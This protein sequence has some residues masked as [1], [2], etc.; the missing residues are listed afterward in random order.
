MDAEVLF[1]KEHR[2]SPEI[3]FIPGQKVNMPRAAALDLI[4]RGIVKQLPKLP[5][6]AEGERQKELEELKEQKNKEQDERKKLVE[7]WVLAYYNLGLK[8]IP[9]KGGYHDKRDKEPNIPE[10]STYFYQP[11]PKE[12]IEQWLKEGKYQNVALLGGD[13]A[14]NDFDDPNSYTELGLNA[15][16]LIDSGAWVTE[17][18]KE[19]GRYHVVVRDKQKNKTTRKSAEGIELRQNEHYWLVYPSIHPNGK[20]YNFLNTKNPDEL[21]LPREVNALAI[22]ETWIQTLKDKRGTTKKFEETIKNKQPFDKSPDCIRLAW[23][24]GAKSGERYYTSI[25]LGSWLQQQGF[26]LEMAQSIVEAW[27]NEKCDTD[28]RPAEDIR[29]GAKVG[30]IKKEYETGCLF[31]R[32]KT[33]YC[34][35]PDTANCPYCEMIGKNKKDLLEKYNAIYEDEKGKF[36]VNCPSLAKLIMEA[37][38]NHYVVMRDNQEIMIY[39][40]S[41]YE[42]NAE[43]HIESRINYYCDSLT[44]NRI[45]S[46]VIGFIKSNGYIYR[47]KMDQ[48]LVLLNFKNG[49]VNMLTGELMP[50]DKRYTFQFEIPVEYND[51]AECILWKK[52]IEDT[53]YQDDVPFI[54]EVCGY[55]LHR[56]YTWA[57]LVIL[58][59]HGRNGKTTF[60]NILSKLLG[61][62]NTEHIPL[63]TI[64]HERF[65]KA[66]LYQKH[67]NL[68]SE[69]GA[70][71]IKDT[72]TL[73]QLTGEDMI[74]ARELYQNG[75]NFRN[76]AKLIFSCNL[77][78]EIGDKTLAMNERL[79][80]VEF[81]NTFERGSPECDPD[82]YDKLTTPEEMSG[83]L[84]WMIEGLKRLMQNKKFSPYR[85]FDNVSEYH[86]SSQ[87]PVKV[88]A[89]TCVVYDANYQ[90][91]KDVVY[92]KYLDFVKEHNYPVLVSSWFSK[93]FKM[94]GPH[95][96]EEGQ[97][98]TGGH[99]TTWIGIKFKDNGDAFPIIDDKQKSLVVE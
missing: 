54:Q 21:T 18:P 29:N 26:P 92:K 37:D 83:I 95:G 93:K 66:K 25:G 27:F 81:P 72:G 96:M 14:C 75:F 42:T 48:P 4:Q 56:R 16:E 7:K 24:H 38:N 84:N 40:G 78:P 88:F 19:P 17:T 34:P 30:Y 70:R 47:E 77:L 51:K 59:G 85:N 97:P 39:N 11:I 22:Y 2:E 67:A 73:K 61:E 52:F 87:D 79:A 58:L 13:L 89:E 63:Q 36:H 9:I 65:A 20:L 99:K 5:R 8:P 91:H 32:E 86:K 3:L 23:E 33:K 94:Y 43:Y 12:T 82:I 62:Q 74:F 50:H 71:E 49:I 10:T 55:L 6:D 15:K 35:Y 1:L 80:V 31:W 57:L 41:F 53:L 76:F 60:L 68:C 46:E 98:R 44:S 28:G 90:L 45:K 69:L 64:A